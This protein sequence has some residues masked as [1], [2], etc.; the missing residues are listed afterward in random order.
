MATRLQ[1][2][3]PHDP[4]GLPPAPSATPPTLAAPGVRRALLTL[5][6][7]VCVGALKLA[8]PAVVPV[9][10]AVFLAL[11]LSPAV[12]GLANRRVPRVVA[13]TLVMVVLLAIAGAFL[14]ATWKPAR[15]WLDAAPATLQQLDRKLRPLTKFIAKV[16]SVSDQAGRM[17]EPGS[18]NDQEPTPV[19]FEPKGF[20][21]STQ[22]WVIAIVS[23][24]FLAL[25]VLATDL[26]KLGEARPPDS[27]WGRAGPVALRVRSE[28]G[29]YFGAVTLS[30]LVLGVGTASAM[31]LLDMPNA[32]LWGVLAFVLNFV[33]Y[34]GSAT[35]LVLLTAV[36]LVSFD[37]VGKAL[38]VAG[39]YLVLTTLEGQ[40]LQPVLVGRRLDVSPP[41]VLLGLWFGGWLW[42]I[43]GVALAMPLLVSA[44]AALREIERSRTAAEPDADTVRTRA[45]HWLRESARR[46]GRGERSAAGG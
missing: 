29:R 39:V 27:P 28:L 23:M 2:P 24:L 4:A 19:A 45:S 3:P 22:E 32:L 14:S 30:N 20:V 5:A 31:Y 7:V 38:T 43:A 1:D 41:I 34:A 11:L 6:V 25:F 16:E 44:K 9:L 8:E 21:Q 35:T 42:G 10:F 26:R 33:P 18:T 40:V 37:G 12:D 36:A 13:A 15:A 46:Y 17:T